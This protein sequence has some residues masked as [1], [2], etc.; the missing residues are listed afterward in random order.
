[1]TTDV[2]LD[3]LLERIKEVISNQPPIKS[4]KEEKDNIKC[5]Y[6]FGYLSQLPKNAP[7][8]EEC[9]LC[10]RVVECIAP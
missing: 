1:M 4:D 6:H 8:P 2:P 3:R 10:S 7:I 9:F 5:P